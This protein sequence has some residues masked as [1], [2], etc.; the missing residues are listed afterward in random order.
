MRNNKVMELYDPSG[1]TLANANRSL[2]C[3]ALTYLSAGRPDAF[4]E[5]ANFYVTDDQFSYVAAVDGMFMREKP[6]ACFYM[7]YYYAES[8]IL[9]ETGSAAGAIQ[10]AGTDAEHQLPFFVTACDYTLIGEEL[11]AAGAYLSK[12]PVKIGTLR[13][14]DAGKLLLM[15]FLLLGA[16]V[17]T[18]CVLWG[19]PDAAAMATQVFKA[20]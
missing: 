11:Y 18:A 9:A 12:E 3:C 19:K 16:A 17:V 4:Q 1:V 15:L 10:I 7:G 6:A 14:Q 20:Y 8:L 2:Y 13:G 5:D